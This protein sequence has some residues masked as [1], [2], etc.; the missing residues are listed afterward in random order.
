MKERTDMLETISSPAQ[1]KTMSLAQKQAL[2]GEIRKTITDT[3]LLNGGHLASNLGA[4][5]LTIALHSVLSA[6]KDKIFFDVGHQCY[7]HKLLTG[8]Y[9]RFDTL[10]KM[11]GVSGFTRPG[12]S[13][14]DHAASGHASDAISLALGMA[15]AR[16][17]CGEDYAVAAVVGD[18]ALTGGMCYEALNDAGQSKARMLIVLNDNEM[19][20]SRNVGSLSK[21]L[22]HMRQSSLYR[23]FKQ[24]LRKLIN[25][26]P[27]G[28]RFTEKLLTRIKDS[29]KTLFVSDLFFD[30]L[31]IEYLG[32]IDG[33]DIREM[34]RVMKS[35]LTYDKPVVVHVITK[36]GKGYAPA[37][38]I[39]DRFHSVPPKDASLEENGETAAAKVG[40]WLL[41]K[42]KADP[43]IVCVSAAM[44]S[45]TGL[46]A[47]SKENPERCFDVGIAEEH[48]A[49][50]AAGLA[51][52]GKKPYLALY[53]TFLQRAYDQMNTDI[54]L[55]RAPVRLLVD[56]SG[57]N[58]PDGETHQGVFDTGLLRGL[59]GMTVCAPASI[60]ELKQILE[61][62]LKND[63]PM[64]IKYPKKLPA[65]EITV[66]SIGEWEEMRAGT[67]VCLIAYGRMVSIA[68]ET[69]NALKENGVSAGVANARFL[70]P[71]D[72]TMLSRILNS[73]P[74]IYTLEDTVLAGSLGEEIATRSE[75]KTKVVVKC[76]P[77]RFIPSG[78]ISQQLDFCGLDRDTIVKEILLDTG[79]GKSDAES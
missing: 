51:L 24:Y 52:G 3:V 1:L 57:L 41:E 28:S 42:A 79:K 64:A 9:A 29:L 26:M 17:L 38:E 44:L 18:G 11:G 22:T 60:L 53:S 58:G 19:S 43:D 32:P 6:P 47:F 13:E 62:S 46:D 69:A 7:A 33:H 30:S 75:G 40:E 10:R 25:R 65:G 67:D 31:D 12:E 77:D 15:R 61:L 74:L 37:E 4:V 49:A 50:M 76:A 39:P 23:S 72:E 34:E 54:A 2:A 35:A 45:G 70:K 27:R 56:R 68:L 36:K 78:T 8:R 14:Y 21:H 63:R 16:D 71:I 48:A 59:P 55:N 73:Y 66:F 20:I 5:E